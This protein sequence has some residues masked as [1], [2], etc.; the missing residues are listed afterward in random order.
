MNRGYLHQIT[1]RHAVIT[2]IDTA[3]RFPELLSDLLEKYRD[4]VELFQQLISDS[5]S[6]DDLLGRIRDDSLPSQKRE[7]VFIEDV[8]ALCCASFRYR[9]SEEDS[10]NLYGRYCRTLSKSFQANAVT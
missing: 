2:I 4:D 8:S 3:T 6:I 1:D 7:N 9:G 5:D 10:K